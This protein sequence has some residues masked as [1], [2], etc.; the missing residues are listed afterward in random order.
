MKMV[1]FIFTL[2][3]MLMV[4]SLH[5]QDVSQIII[6][7]TRFTI[8]TNNYQNDYNLIYINWYN[9]HLS[10]DTLV[11]GEDLS[12]LNNFTRNISLGEPAEAMIRLF[13]I[14]LGEVRV[15][16]IGSCQLFYDK[17]SN[18]LIGY[19]I[20]FEDYTSN[21][22]LEGIL[23]VSQE[24]YRTFRPSRTISVGGKYD[25]SDRSKN[26]ISEYSVTA[27]L[28]TGASLYSI[29]VTSEVFTRINES[30]QW[31]IQAQRS[32]P[33]SYSFTVY[34]LLTL[35]QIEAN[36]ERQLHTEQE[37]K[38]AE[39]ERRIHEQQE[40]ERLARLAEEAHQ[41]AREEQERNRREQERLAEEA[42]QREEVRAREEQ[43]RNRR[44]QERLAEEA[45]QNARRARQMQIVGEFLSM[46][47]QMGI[48]SKV[49][50]GSNLNNQE[51]QNFIRLYR[52]YLELMQQDIRSNVNHN[53]DDL[54]IAG[55]QNSLPSEMREIYQRSLSNRQRRDF[56]N[57][58]G[59]I[60]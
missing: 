11:E 10:S 33:E 54:A 47:Y 58:F 12:W 37:Q 32:L 34:N 57:E 15:L 6:N 3:L 16:T 28:I 27:F 60:R 2:M 22:T 25:G 38:R 13:E 7:N 4:V 42:R 21:R 53:R 31:Y 39:E 48:Q 45:R 26:I 44:E 30:R 29:Q 59:P 50:A 1:T 46:D 19:Y 49:N 35:S 9:R 18:I 41:R 23:N 55:M 43:E 36:R 40:Q 51:F 52:L 8:G 20:E 56:D 5:S 14:E 17:D 24:Y